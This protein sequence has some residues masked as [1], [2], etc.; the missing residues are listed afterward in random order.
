MGQKRRIKKAD[1]RYVP[2]IPDLIDAIHNHNPE[3]KIISKIDGDYTTPPCDFDYHEVL[4]TYLSEK[5]ALTI[6]LYIS[7]GKTF[8]EIGDV[9]LCSR[10]YAHQLYKSSLEKLRPILTGLHLEKQKPLDNRIEMNLFI[11]T[12]NKE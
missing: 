3:D 2:Y 9:L 6:E 5:E 12:T 7:E 8:Q 11:R 4:S 1:W 10:Q